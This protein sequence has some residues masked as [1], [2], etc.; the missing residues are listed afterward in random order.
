MPSD[1]TTPASKASIDRLTL[2]AEPVRGAH[3]DAWGICACL[4]TESETAPSG[5]SLCACGCAC[6]AD[7]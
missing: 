1:I 4:C 7:D 2:G 5:I 6:A 3:P